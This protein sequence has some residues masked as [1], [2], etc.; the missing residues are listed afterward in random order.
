M[1][2]SERIK[3][4]KNLNKDE[5]QKKK[6]FESQIQLRKNKRNETLQKRRNIVEVDLDSSPGKENAK[7]YNENLGSPE[8]M[9]RMICNDSD[10]SGQLEGVRKIRKSLSRNTNPP[11]HVFIKL[12]AIPKLVSF[13]SWNHNTD[14]QFE[15][16]WAITNVASGNSE[17]TKQL[18][19]HKAVE[20]LIEL[21]LCEEKVADQAIWALGNIAGDSPV[22]RNLVLEC[23]ILNNLLTLA[24]H[25]TS[26][27]ENNIHRIR[28]I[29]WT[30]TNLCRNRYPPTEMRYIE[31]IL[32]LINQLMLIP[33]TQVVTDALWGLSYVTDCPV[34]RVNKVIELKMHVTL[35][36][37]LAAC[38]LNT[39]EIVLPA[40]RSLGNIAS[41]SEM[42]TQVLIDCNFAVALSIIIQKKFE[43]NNLNKELCWVLS[44]LFAGSPAQIQKVLDCNLLPWVIDQCNFGDFRVRK[45]AVWAITN[46]INSGNEDQTTCAINCSGIEALCSMLDCMD[47]SI[48]ETAMNGLHSLCSKENLRCTA[49]YKIE[50]C[51]GLDK[52]EQLQQHD[53]ENIYQ[54]SFCIIDRFFSDAVNDCDV[55]TKE[56]EN[57]KF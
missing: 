48:C 9:V 46:L 22:F 15:A 54:M 4:Y 5:Q 14:M 28:N 51:G 10:S 23:N 52:I 53:N 50:E 49:T 1:S 20:P 42:Q 33:D 25:I 24:G 35:I 39:K 34:D 41:G 17:Q 11:I 32:P 38:D 26:N 8:E 12:G 43:V 56:P 47:A 57:F 29:A 7:P 27:Y 3:S 55:D 40:L 6:R 2:S 13:L 30:C 16:C 37:M 36:S 18:V 21:L 31:H 44:N 45:E 19:E